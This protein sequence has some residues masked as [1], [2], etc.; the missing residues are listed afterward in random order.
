MRIMR[1]MRIMRKR[2]RELSFLGAKEEELK[3]AGW[4]IQ[5]EGEILVDKEECGFTIS[6]IR[7]SSAPWVQTVCDAWTHRSLKCFIPQVPWVQNLERCGPISRENAFNT[8]Q[9]F[10]GSRQLTRRYT[11]IAGLLV[12]WSTW[13]APSPFYAVT[14]MPASLRL[15]CKTYFE[16]SSSRNGVSYIFW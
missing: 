16:N 9:A 2:E 8:L 4:R 13:S 14:K 11:F 12:S 5:R 15:R 1:I 3:M 7:Y 6:K 10:H